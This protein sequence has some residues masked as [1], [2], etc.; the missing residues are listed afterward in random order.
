[1]TKLYFR[2]G[3][4]NS[5]KTANLLMS[6][7]N[8]RKQNKKVITIKPSIDD[9]FGDKT[10]QSRAIEGVEADII[11]NQSE[12]QI[13]IPDDVKYVYVDE[14]Q[15]L[16]ELN[17]YGLRKISK[18]ANVYCY[19]LR[20]DYKLNLFS[21]SEALFKLADVIE[22]IETECIL[23]ENKAIVNAKIV[24]GYVCKEGSSEPD[25]GCEEKYRPMCWECWNTKIYWGTKI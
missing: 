8:H 13:N 15:F 20:T 9:R 4:M 17:I 6:V 5:A 14:C 2:F 24:N 25:L 16:S 7:H 12:Y 22:E 11:L 19:G 3:T 10:I 18:K 23:C 1:M 21:G